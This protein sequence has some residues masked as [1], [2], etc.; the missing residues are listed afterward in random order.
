MMIR[1]SA[2]SLTFAQLLRVRRTTAVPQLLRV[3]RTMAEPQLLRDRRTM[4]VPC[5]GTEVE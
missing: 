3:R 5:G 4:A 2:A 1:E